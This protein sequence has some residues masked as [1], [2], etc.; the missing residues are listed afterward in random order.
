MSEH[1]IH[2]KNELLKKEFPGVYEAL[3]KG[4]NFLMICMN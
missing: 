2:N 4:I 3:P 1:F